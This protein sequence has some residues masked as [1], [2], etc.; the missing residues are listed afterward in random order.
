MQL[1]PWN[2]APQ[3]L[4]GLGAWLWLCMSTAPPN[5]RCTAVAPSLEQPGQQ[6]QA[7]LGR[8]WQR[9]QGQQGQGQEQRMGA[10]VQSQ[11]ASQVQSWWRRE[12][13]RRCCRLRICSRHCSRQKPDVGLPVAAILARGWQGPH[14]PRRRL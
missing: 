5:V 7:Q 4:L 1:M 14:P 10:Q 9:A 8:Q 11:A 12:V 3:A 2:L 13:C 6:G